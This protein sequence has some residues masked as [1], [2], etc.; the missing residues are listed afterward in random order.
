MLGEDNGV[1]FAGGVLINMALV[2]ICVFVSVSLPGNPS[3]TSV[4]IRN[5]DDDE[6][7]YAR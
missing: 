1:R 2:L 4:M 5:N 3:R 6:K 7:V